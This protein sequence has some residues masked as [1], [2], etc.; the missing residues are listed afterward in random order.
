MYS[1][2]I[3]RSSKTL[4]SLGS[5]CP[6]TPALAR[7]HQMPSG[8]LSEEQ[9]LSQPSNV[10]GNTATYQL[11]SVHSRWQGD[12]YCPLPRRPSER[13][14]RWL[15]G[16]Q[17]LLAHPC[18]HCRGCSSLGRSRG[19]KA[20]VGGRAPGEGERA[21]PGLRRPGDLWLRAV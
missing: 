18:R 4:P 15:R 17:G 13:V 7:R 9:A 12:T 20:P 3:T 1:P 10:L 8:S 14:A 11:G 5:L 16:P 2:D 21:S 19:I 6:P